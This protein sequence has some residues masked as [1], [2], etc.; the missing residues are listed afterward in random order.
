MTLICAFPF[1]KSI[2]FGL[3]NYSS[4]KTWINMKRKDNVTKNFLPI[5]F[6]LSRW[7]I[8]F[9]N[10]GN[11]QTKSII[12]DNYYARLKKWDVSIL[13]PKHC[14]LY[15]EIYQRMGNI[16]YISKAYKYFS[17]SVLCFGV[18]G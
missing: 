11:K 18:V 1:V 4:V 3:T 13:I 15:H 5:H 9:L 10:K 17:S 16:S 14:I 8:F 2:I 12:W 7:V 6:H